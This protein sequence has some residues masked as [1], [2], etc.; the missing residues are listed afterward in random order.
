MAERSFF[1]PKYSFPYYEERTVSFDYFPGFALSQ[2]QKSII[3]MH[4]SIKDSCGLDKILEVSTKSESVIGV[5]LSAFN[6]MLDYQG[7][8]ASVESI[9]QSSKTFTKGGPFRDIAWKSSL[10]S[11]KDERLKSSGA[12]LHFEHE[13]II[14]PLISSP[15]FYDFLYI[16]ALS[17]SKFVA[18]IKNYEAFSDFAYSTQIGKAKIGKSWNCQARSVAIFR[19]MSSTY[20]GPELLKLL[21]ECALDS[22]REM[23]DGPLTLF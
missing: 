17:Q 20:N 4:Q 23:K 18:E 5:S 21:S 6:L 15:N 3:S 19:G 10:E 14:W 13:G 8:R 16:S 7:H 12:L 2:Q 11:K 9:Y 1:I 22:S